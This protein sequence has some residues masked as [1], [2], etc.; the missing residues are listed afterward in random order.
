[1][2]P[3]TL[4]A[5]LVLLAVLP[6]ADVRGAGDLLEAEGWPA[7]L[8]R[9][10]GAD[11]DG[12]GVPNDLHW[13]VLPVLVYESPRLQP[14]WAVAWREAATRL[15]LELAR[16]VFLDA[17][18]ADELMRV[19]CEVGGLQPTLGIYLSG[20]GEDPRHGVTTIAR[21]P[22]GRI[23]TALV[24]LPAAGAPPGRAA[25]IALHEALHAL[26]VAHDASPR[27]IMH[28]AAGTALPRATVLLLRR[29][30]R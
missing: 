18:P 15:E 3:V 19:R 9:A 14:T 24:E 27:S 20:S 2:T 16:T 4:I 13:P 28:P 29:T 25:L 10:P 5:R 1:V 17:G 23:R 21:W 22:D 6:I 26:G 7:E 12:D 8:R 30:Y 11:L